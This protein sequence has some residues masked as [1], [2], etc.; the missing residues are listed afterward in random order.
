MMR[1][2]VYYMTFKS[3]TIYPISFCQSS[4]SNMKSF[5]FS[6]NATDRSFRKSTIVNLAFNL[7][8]FFTF[9]LYQYWL[10]VAIF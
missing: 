8:T 9:Y 7:D 5:S 10:V 3:I 4:A 2:I 6:Q 1:H